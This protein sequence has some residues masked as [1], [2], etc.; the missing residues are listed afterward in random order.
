MAGERLGPSNAA[1][2][3]APPAAPMMETPVSTTVIAGPTIDSQGRI[4]GLS[5]DYVP[6]TYFNPDDSSISQREIEIQELKRAIENLPLGW[7]G[8][9]PGNSNQIK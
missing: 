6:G 8:D 5:P 9:E 3:Q 7:L 1:A 4:D 2:W